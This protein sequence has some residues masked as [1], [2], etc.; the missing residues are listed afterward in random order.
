MSCIADSINP[1]LTLF[2]AQTL[3]AI[4]KQFLMELPGNW[5]CC[6]LFPSSYSLACLFHIDPLLTYELGPL[7]L[8][9]AQSTESTKKRMLHINELVNKLPEGTE[10]SF[11]TF[12]TLSIIHM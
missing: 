1:D 12:S 6:L 2:S 3:G 5:L 4:L 7:F 8:Q 10:A 9:A 11:I